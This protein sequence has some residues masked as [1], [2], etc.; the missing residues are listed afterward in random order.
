MNLSAV[1]AR[2]EINK[3][4][5]KKL[6][7]AAACLLAQQSLSGGPVAFEEIGEK[8]IENQFL[9]ELSAK[10][11]P[12]LKTVVPTAAENLSFKMWHPSDAQI[13]ALTAQYYSTLAQ[14]KQLRI[15]LFPSMY[16][17]DVLPPQQIN[18][19]L[20]DI[21]GVMAGITQMEK[22]VEG[23]D[24]ALCDEKE[25]MAIFTTYFSAPA[26]WQAASLARPLS[27]DAL[28]PRPDRVFN[29]DEFFLQEP[30]WL[31]RKREELFPLPGKMKV[32]VLND[33]EEILK[34][35]LRM[36]ETVDG[37]QWTIDGFLSPEDFLGQPDVRS[38]DMVLT[39]L[40]LRPGGGVYVA[41]RLRQMGYQNPIL[42]IS[43]YDEEPFLAKQLYNNEIDGMYAAG[44]MAALRVPQIHE[45]VMDKM[46]NYFY[47][48]EKGKWKR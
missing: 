24:R 5:R 44:T 41:L 16:Y 47:Y 29:E 33:D 13:Q 15:G 30:D 37:A 25:N 19:N 10:M 9:R 6:A 17:A 1:R 40:N 45:V 35:L 7:L 43:A 42:A 11:I 18:Q 2:K 39:D 26:N 4:G 12:H 46:R 31:M 8:L 48:K 3:M 38:Y 22:F 36:K 27:G 21:A 23:E 14:A 34:G 20:S 28:P 32:A